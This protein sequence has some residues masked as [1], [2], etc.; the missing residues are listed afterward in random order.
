MIRWRHDLFLRV[1]NVL[2]QTSAIY[3]KTEGGIALPLVVLGIY[4]AIRALSSS[5]VCVSHHDSLGVVV[6]I[7]AKSTCAHDACIPHG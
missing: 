5:D 6:H 4:E 2:L 7:L 1:I 3:T